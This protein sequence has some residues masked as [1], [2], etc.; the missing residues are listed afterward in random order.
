MPE[1]GSFQPGA[2]ES[3]NNR[4]VPPQDFRYLLQQ[5]FGN[6]RDAFRRIHRDVLKF[7]IEADGQVSRNG[8]G[9]CCPDQ[10]INFTARQGPIEKRGIGNQR[11]PDIDGRAGVVFILHFRLRQRGSILNAPMNRLQA[12]IHVTALQEVNERLSDHGLVL[13]AHRE[14][15]ISPAS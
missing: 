14:I 7:R 5:A 9:R 4:P 3:G 2:W 15:W 6:N 11:E 10:A 1:Y 8:P 13:G 12:F